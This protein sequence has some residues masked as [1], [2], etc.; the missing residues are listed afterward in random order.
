MNTLS[1]FHPLVA[2]WFAENVGTPTDIQNLAWPEIA[3]RKHVLVIAPTGSGKTLTA[4]MWAINNF[5]AVSETGTGRRILYISPL[6]ALNNDIR[7][8]LQVPLE[9]LKTYFAADG[10]SFPDIRTAVRSGDTDQSERRSIL[11]HPP[12]ILIT[13]PESLNI[14]ISSK[15]GMR[16]LTG[17][18]TVILDEIHS[19]APTKRG[20]YLMS[21]VER[22]VPL[23]GEFQRIALSATVK[24]SGLIADFVGGYTA[25]QA[26]GTFI[27]DKRTVHVLKSDAKK[28]YSISV[29]FPETDTDPDHEKDWWRSITGSLKDTIAKNRS[30]LIFAN[31]RRMVEKVTRLINEN[32]ETDRVYSHHGSLSK[33]IRTVVEKR[34]KEGE[35]SA[36]VATSSLELGIDIGMVD[37]VV[38][39]QTP[40]SIASAIQR[41]GRSGHGVGQVSRGSFQ[42]IHANDFIEACV[43]AEYID[44]DDIESIDIVENPLDVLAQVLLSMILHE[45]RD[46]DELYGEIRACS[47]F[48]HLKRKEFD[49]VIE[50]LAGRYA[51]SRIRELKPRLFLDRVK[52]TIKARDNARLLLYL[53]GGVIPDRGYYNM[54]V[55]D[56]KAKIGE[57]D[58]EFVWERSLGDAFPFGNQIWRIQRIT[59]N[60]VEVQ[61]VR[62]SNSLIP[63]WKAEDMNRSFHLSE[64]IGLFLEEANNSLKSDEFRDTLITRNR[65]SET[66]ADYLI[67]FLARQKE[68]TGIL[69]HRHQILIEHFRDPANVSDSKQTVLHTMWGGQINRPLAL[70]L[71]EAWEIKYKYPLEVF[72]NNDCIILNLPHDFN[73]GD[74]VSLVESG[75]INRLLRSRLVSTGYFGAKFREN[76]QRALLLPRKSFHERMPFWL[77]RL[78]SKKLI[79]AVS[80]FD[81]FPVILETWRTCLNHEFDLDK[82]DM[83]L[84]EIRTGEI[85]ITEADTINPSP[86]ASG[87]IWRQTNHYM[88]AD[89]APFSKLKSNLSDDLLREVLYS[90]HLR[91][92]FSDELIREFVRKIQRTAPGYAPETPEEL[93]DW[94]R[95]R[96][97]IPANEWEELL[98]AI[99]GSTIGETSEIIGP[100][101]DRIFRFKV[102][103]KLKAVAAL[104]NAPRIA[105]S[106]GKNIED[107]ET[108]E[109]KLSISDNV[110]DST[111]SLLTDFLFEWLRFYGPVTFAFIRETLCVD[112]AKL[113]GALQELNEDRRIVIDEFR[114]SASA[115][116]DT[117]INEEI[118]DSGNL[119]ILLRLK[120]QADRPVFE[121]LELSE[122]PGFLARYQGLVNTGEGLE[123]LQER[124]ER[125]FGYTARAALW[126]TDIFPARLSPY[127]TS[128][129]DSAMRE[130]D[131]VWFGSGKERIGFCFAQDLEL[132]TSV[133]KNSPDEDEQAH[134]EAYAELDTIF[135][136]M[137]GKRNFTD[138]MNSSKFPVVETAA[139]LWNMAWEGRV[140]NDDYGAVRKGIQ[141]SFKAAKLPE[142]RGRLR[143]SGFNRWKNV[144]PFT[145]NWYALDSQQDEEIDVLDR[146]ELEKDRI[147][148]L[149][150]RY[151]ILFRDLLKNELP[152]LKW[153]SLFRTLRLMELSGEIFTG[154]FFTGISGP[155]FCSHTAFRMLNDPFPDNT[156]YWMNA[157]DPAS[158]CGIGLEE[159]KSSFPPRLAT[160]HLVFHGTAVVLISKRNGKELEFMVP[161]DNTA[162]SDYLGFFSILLT[163][164]FKPLKLIRVE[165]INGLPAL[166]SP[167]RSV[168]L[169]SGFRKDFKSLIL[170]KSYA[171]GSSR[172]L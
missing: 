35:L 120:R 32:E 55:A 19:V 18:S 108:I 140:T 100:V 16:L 88:Y 112:T 45:S 170:Q 118:C 31:S 65:M 57:L 89:D 36:I 141:N 22:L 160:T 97:Y 29:N 40:Y 106:L 87:I 131:L 80:R 9:G 158:L 10:T 64:K 96:L 71:S 159:L 41:I 155:Q 49:L 107:I 136:D 142:K 73:A 58:E 138:I 24:P 34:L 125:L 21:A 12:D 46:I 52:N 74:I 38:L 124:L 114:S 43:L 157:A 28:D 132:F 14:L 11:R 91:P 105:T 103:D 77:N 62:K 82:L 113:S 66:A 68:E 151:G 150:M 72:A 99:N 51:D 84:G 164:Q 128:W 165:V 145:G 137:P 42:P 95:E 1:L 115:L 122:L 8:N 172:A 5:L 50:M 93:L 166:D 146:Q 48:R 61:Q 79:E 169:N 86:F 162:I 127:Y 4:F 56:T 101:E 109:E 139:A 171:S 167:Y 69:P 67:D 161:H 6:K 47:A 13:T 53:S 94:L 135:S 90:S 26:N 37:E 129:L 153:G 81:D 117:E 149:F 130:S 126:E 25:R 102:N 110:S 20:T 92:R 168:L 59:H 111:D 148:Q 133:V 60:D 23:C 121:P 163:R 3:R 144:K 147:R 116:P 134:N 44:S 7:R 76:A 39:I 63:F 75:D 83:L 143:R 119:E 154:Q 54:R 78:R 30:T 15:S 104:E 123:D 98:T 152:S 156:V 85:R 33:E 17:I 70:A 2:S 27:Y